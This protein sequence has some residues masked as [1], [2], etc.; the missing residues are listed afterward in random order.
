MS[1]KHPASK[2]RKARKA[3]RRT[4]ADKS[5]KE[6]AGSLESKLLKPFT[7]PDCKRTVALAEMI[8]D[9]RVRRAAAGT[10]KKALVERRD[11]ALSEGNKRLCEQLAEQFMEAVE[12]QKL[13]KQSE[14][15]A[16]DDLAK[17]LTHDLADGA[18]VWQAAEDAKEGEG[19]EPN[20][21]AQLKLGGDATENPLDR[22]E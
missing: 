16:V 3:T 21:P 5:K 8:C 18:T 19:Q 9:Q 2:P 20:D 12:E 13:A 15:A 1:K 22:Q 17:L 10:R 4:V 7:L 14:A 6:K 11:K